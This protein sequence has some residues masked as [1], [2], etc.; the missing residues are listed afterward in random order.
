A[1]DPEYVLHHLTSRSSMQPALA[2]LAEYLR[3]RMPGP[4]VTRESLRTRSWWS[5]AE[6]FVVVD[7]HDVVTAGGWQE[8]GL[9]LLAP[10]IPVAAEIGLHVLV[11]QRS[12]GFRASDPLIGALEDLRVPTLT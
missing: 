9:H 1:V 3:G 6:V 12:N 7:D 10:L 8:S 11:A 4:D 5:G 2:A